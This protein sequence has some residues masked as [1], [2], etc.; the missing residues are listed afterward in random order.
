MQPYMPLRRVICGWAL[1]ITLALAA[2]LAAGDVFAMPNGV[3]SMDLVSI[4]NPGNLQDGVF[5]TRGVVS[6]VYSI[7]KF[8]VT[9]AQYAQFLNAVAER[10][11]YGLYNPAMGTWNGLGQTDVG[12]TFSYSVQEDYRNRPISL[13]SW[14]DAARFCNWLTNGQPSGA[15]EATTTE[16][17]LYLLDGATADA[18]LAAVIRRPGKGYCVPTL[19]EWYKA[20]YHKNDGATG[21]YYAYAT[22]SDLHPGNQ[23]LF[24]DPGNNANHT[25]FDTLTLG[26]PYYVTEVGAFANSTSPYGTFD[27]TGNVQEWTEYG[28]PLARDALGGAF[29]HAWGIDKSE[30][31]NAY[32]PGWELS[33]LGFRVTYLPEPSCMVLLSL[34]AM[35][36]VHLRRPSQRR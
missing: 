17:G 20:A 36:P 24:P 3:T 5:G 1:L 16:D 28:A 23:I 30:A 13:V 11:T 31:Q 26:A 14:G 29:D 33:D 4:G 25:I 6:Y 35:V 19:N 15:Q 34:F 21:D 22:S 18:D 8:E 27:Q 12:G 2:G 32:P 10:D 7:G 9:V